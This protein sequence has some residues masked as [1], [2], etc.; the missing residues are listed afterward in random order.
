M[1]HLLK[2]CTLSLQKNLSY[3]KSDTWNR[4]NRFL[5]QSIASTTKGNIYN[6]SI[7][8]IVENID[9]IRCGCWYKVTATRNR[10]AT[11]AYLGEIK[12][13]KESF[14]VKSHLLQWYPL[15]P[16]VE[17]LLNHSWPYWSLVNHLKDAFAS[18]CKTCI[19]VPALWPV[20]YMNNLRLSIEDNPIMFLK[21]FY[22]SKYCS[23]M[24]ALVHDKE[25][26]CLVQLNELQSAALNECWLQSQPTNLSILDFIP[27]FLKGL[28]STKIYIVNVKLSC[29]YV[30][31]LIF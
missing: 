16:L 12:E 4:E 13:H 3:L 25:L 7:I 31:T 27:Q 18:S 14:R 5:L 22:P 9:F 17:L 21:D 23:T 8:C 15:H 24:I 11:V 10:S 6:S 30:Q 20:C 2:H 29:S 19:Y 1:L 28:T 26:L